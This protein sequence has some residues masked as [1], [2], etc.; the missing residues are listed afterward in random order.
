[1]LLL[2]TRDGAWMRQCEAALM[3]E[4]IEM[5]WRRAESAPGMGL[6]IAASEVERASDVLSE[7]LGEDLRRP[8]RMFRGVEVPLLLQPSFVAAL[9]MAA[10]TLTWF[11]VTG[12]ARGETVWFERGKLVSEA[13]FA[14]EVWRLVTAATLHADW[15]HA[16]GNAGFF[17]VLGWG[18]G[19]RLGPGAAVLVWLL[20]AI[21]GFVA[22]LGLGDAVVTV[23]ASG[24]LF[25]LLGVA[26]GHATRNAS[27]TTAF[28]RRRERLRAL[29]AG[30]MLLAFSAFSP[31][32]NIH[33]HVGGFVVG[34]AF[35]WVAPPQPPRAWLQGLMGA[36]TLV[37][38]VMA[39]QMGYAA[40]GR[41]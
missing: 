11:W 14:G 37:A 17:V 39:W 38:V 5:R 25:G 35:G 9:G 24:G 7:Q 33:A 10:L 41:G 8:P 22:S 40:V 2:S 27:A 23:G 34:M 20:T 3:S 31:E 26:A 30:V 28:E 32:S 18:A 1:M 21:S 4:G 36:G 16:L 15:G 19:E 6:D 12:G 13:A 29:G